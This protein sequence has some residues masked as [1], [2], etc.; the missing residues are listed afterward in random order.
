MSATAFGGS[1]DLVRTDDT[2]LRDAIKER[3]KRA[4]LNATIPFFSHLLGPPAGAEKIGKIV[5]EVLKKRQVQVKR[6]RNNDLLQILLDAHNENPIEFSEAHVRD[7]MRNMMSV[8]FVSA[9]PFS[10]LFV[11]KR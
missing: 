1:F 3:S 8:L 2:I 6:E 11:G 9:P 4:V 7:E 5:D 10:I